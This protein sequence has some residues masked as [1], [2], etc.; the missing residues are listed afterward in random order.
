MSRRVPKR[1]KSILRKRGRIDNFKDELME[2][3]I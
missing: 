1:Y 3:W 2:Y